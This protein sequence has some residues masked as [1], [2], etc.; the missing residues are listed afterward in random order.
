MKSF[1]LRQ[2]FIAGL[3]FAA[4][5]LPGFAASVTLKPVA[6]AMLDELSPSSNS[7]GTSDLVAGT[8]GSN[9]GSLRRRIVLKFDLAGQIPPG[10]TIISVTMTINVVARTPLG[11]ANSNFLLRQVTQ[12]WKEMEVTWLARQTGASWN[13]EGGDF[14][15]VSRASIPVTGLGSY[16]FGSTAGLVSDLQNW[17]NDSTS[18]N[19]WILMSD[20]ELVSKTARHFAPREDVANAPALTIVYTLPASPPAV[21][22]SSPL[23]AGIYAMPYSQTLVATGGTPGYTWSVVAG[24][25]PGGLT[26]R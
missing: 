21:A 24:S 6:D 23:A 9:V 20:S 3:F 12:S 7:G 14:T 8:L 5:V 13:A 10:A 4:F 2:C 11:A 17:L 1:L 26:A 19:G 22:N 15:G 25:L 18:N 16:Q